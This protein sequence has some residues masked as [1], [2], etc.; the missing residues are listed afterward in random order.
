[1]GPY[2]RHCFLLLSAVIFD[3]LAC[4]ISHAEQRVVTTTKT[5]DTL[6]IRQSMVRLTPVQKNNL[7]YEM[8]AKQQ[9]FNNAEKAYK[10]CKESLDN[11]QCWKMYE[12]DLS[13]AGQK[14]PSALM[15]LKQDVLYVIL[16]YQPIV[17][18][19]NRQKKLGEKA[20]VIC[21]NP[22]VPSGYWK[23]V[24][25]YKPVLKNAPNVDGEIV[26][27]VELLKKRACQAFV[28]FTGKLG[29]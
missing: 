17:T 4:A 14:V 28:K 8:A 1:M 20:L 15:R 26:E 11:Y 25:R 18:D 23:V 16:E 7:F 27:P 6:E 19:L 3:W 21:L 22:D 2:R 12:G 9:E 29:R 10:L 13:Q 5:G 24:N